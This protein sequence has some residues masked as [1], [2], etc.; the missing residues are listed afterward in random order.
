MVQII[1]GMLIGMF[2][3]V[4]RGLTILTLWG[5]FVSTHFSSPPLSMATA[6]GISLIMSIIT[7]RYFLKSELDEMKNASPADGLY[8]TMYNGLMQVVNM[9]IILALGFAIHLWW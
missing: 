3:L 6:M 5:W 2:L 4:F 9:L 1:I 8:T 7:Q